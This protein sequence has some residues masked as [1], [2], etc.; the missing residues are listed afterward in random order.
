M[1]N[2]NVKVKGKKS[3]IEASALET[4]YAGDSN[5]QFHRKR[6]Q[7]VAKLKSFKEKKTIKR[8]RKLKLN[9]ENT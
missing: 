6:Q 8:V 2:G 4:T 9:L 5:N 7:S 3:S 1:E